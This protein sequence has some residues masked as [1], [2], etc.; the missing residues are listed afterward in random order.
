MLDL[1]AAMCLM[2][3]KQQVSNILPTLLEFLWAYWG[4]GEIDSF[5]TVWQV[6][7]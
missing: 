1:A 5:N 4:K 7:R 6:T 2:V 3:E